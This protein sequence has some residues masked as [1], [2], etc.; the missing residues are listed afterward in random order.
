ML[1]T[2]GKIWKNKVFM[3][4]AILILITFPNTLYKQ[5]DKD[6]TIVATSIGIE[7]KDDKYSVSILAVIP[8]GESDVNSNLEIFE[9]EGNTISEAL[10]SITLD[11][12]RKIGLAHCDCIVFTEE[13]MQGNLTQ[14]L[15]YFTRTANLST[16]P[17]LIATPTSAKE[18]LNSVKSSNNLLDLSLKNIISSQEDR[19]L[20]K[21]ITLDRFYRAYFSPNST[22]TIPILTTDKSS[23]SSN[24]N[25]AGGSGGSSGGESNLPEENSGG[26]SSG[27]GGGKPQA[28]IKNDNQIAVLRDGRLIG[29]LSED[30]QFIYNLLTNP[31]SYQKFVL[32]NINDENFKNSTVVFQEADKIIIPKYKFVDGKPVAEFNIWLSVMIDEVHST[33][34]NSYSSISGTQNFLTDTIKDEFKKLISE[35]LETTNTLMREN[36]YDIMNLYSKF[37]AYKYRKFYDYQ[38]TLENQTEYMT[39]MSIKINIKL[40]YVI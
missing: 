30:E 37:N 19:T 33:E 39:N 36:R 16:N 22:F 38:Q 40:N 3:V 11:L 24:S 14:I 18:L 25:S 20:L 26:G 9:A 8:K 28:K 13:I 31:S 15:D 35:K 21:N 5:S 2:I 4:I 17:T 1:N 34:N 10:D 23:G 27:G 32:K 29:H 7:K 6:T 12:G